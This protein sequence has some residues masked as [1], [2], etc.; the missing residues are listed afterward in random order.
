MKVSSKCF[1]SFLAISVF[2]LFS[3]IRMDAFAQQAELEWDADSGQVAGYN[4]YY[5]PSTRNYTT[6]VDAGAS[7]TYTMQ[8]LSSSTYYVAVT[9]Y[10][11]SNNESAYS[12][13]LVI[14]PVTASAG[15]GGSI[16]PSGTFFVSQGS[17]QTF[18]ITPASGYSVGNVTVDGT[19]VGAVT[20][21]TLSNVSAGHTIS[22]TFT[23]SS[24]ASY[25]ITPSAGTGGSISPSTAVTVTAGGSQTFTITP[26]SGYSIGSVL[27]DG[28]SI[29]A[30]A[31]Y[32]FSNVS[33]NHTIS[34][35]FTQNPVPVTASYTITPSAGANG[36]LSPSSAVKVTAGGSQTFTISPAANYRIQNVLVDNVSVGTVASYTF[37]N[38]S[39]N[40]TIAATF[41]SSSTAYSITASVQ[42]SGKISPSGTVSVKP[43]ASKT[44]LISAST[45]YRI[46]SV[47]VD[48][49]S[50]GAVS[51]YTFS[52]V[53]ANHTITA[54]FTSNGKLR[55]HA[56]TLGGGSITPSGQ[57][58]ATTGASASFTIKPSAKH[59]LTSVLIDGTAVTSLSNGKVLG[60]SGVDQ[61][62]TYTFSNLTSNH[63][64]E[65]VFSKIPP[66]VADAGPDQTATAG[67]TVVLNG[68]NS[69]DSVVG[70]ASYSWTQ[71]KGPK[72]ALSDPSSPVCSFTA[73]NVSKDKLLAFKLT[74]TDNA[75]LQKS[76]SCLVNLP[77]NDQAPSAEAGPNQTVH[78]YSIV[79]L[80]GS[81]STDPDSQAVTY[82]WVQVKGPKVEISNAQTKHASF[83]APATGTQGAT[84][85]FQLRVTDQ[86]GLATRDQCTVNVTEAAQPPTA[87][88]GQAQAAAESD[89]VTLDASASQVQNGASIV[90]RW[91]QVRGVPVTLSDPSAQTPVFIVP[92]GTATANS[93]LLFRLTVTDADSLLSSTAECAIKVGAK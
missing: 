88:A 26:A 6:K 25:T 65:A 56:T 76:D 18:T 85:V 48:G 53:S 54:T 31:S 21:Y 13:E 51:S 72:V 28:T 38:V 79:N 22:A 59:R 23:Q 16:S 77:A 3:L 8:S 75:G 10:D 32:T 14:Y 15:T 5:G 29:G 37:S 27:V 81:G 35:T 61:A 66:P 90:Y 39:A 34:A 57:V 78:A 70:I 20:S 43:G 69:T 92:E 74:V 47:S 93:S 60:S 12:S 44:F 86:S 91:K 50:V 67:S 45:G 40:H 73:P 49:T 89:P 64:I 87:D 71:T 63:S 33:A 82:N 55:I 80:D 4:V 17:A 7:T 84:L 62:V 9:A 58:N 11:S 83:A 2:L 41:V 19:S 36:S 46:S 68:S 1:P 52:K 24:N 30:Q 42:G